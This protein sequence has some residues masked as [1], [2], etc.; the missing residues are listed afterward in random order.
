M[1]SFKGSF[2]SSVGDIACARMGCKECIHN[3]AATQWLRNRPRQVQRL[4]TLD[5]DRPWQ[6]RLG[7][8]AEARC[9]PRAAKEFHALI[10]ALKPTRPGR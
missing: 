5:G 10:Q 6:A 4:T 7:V 8:D 2:N 9:G 1:H 3:V